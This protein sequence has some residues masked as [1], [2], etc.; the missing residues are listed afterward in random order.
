MIATLSEVLTAVVR[1]LAFQRVVYPQAAPRPLSSH[2]AVIEQELFECRAE[3]VRGTRNRADAL[4]EMVQV[5]ACAVAALIENGVC[6]RNY[7]AEVI[8]RWPTGLTVGRSAGMIYDTLAGLN[9][10]W[11]AAACE[12]IDGGLEPDREAR[13]REEANAVVSL[14]AAA[15]A[16]RDRLAAISSRPS[17][18]LT[19]ADQLEL[20]RLI[21]KLDVALNPSIT[22][23]ERP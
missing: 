5:A 19:D 1:E 23:E 17:G 6:E 3:A 22:A 11:P 9:P 4:R 16:V 8:R 10:P 18:V 20:V 7:V 13:I 12:P 14:P 2:V 15:G 21:R